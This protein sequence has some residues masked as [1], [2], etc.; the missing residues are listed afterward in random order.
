MANPNTMLLHGNL[1][2]FSCLGAEIYSHSAFFTL[3]GKFCLDSK[4]DL[5]S[6]RGVLNLTKALTQAEKYNCNCGEWV[7]T[8]CHLRPCNHSHGILHSNGSPVN[9]ILL[10]TWATL[11]KVGEGHG[12]W[13]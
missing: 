11:V 9:E 3:L 1:S 2:L 12:L 6:G 13:R 8:T 4:Q 7:R 10:W 5:D